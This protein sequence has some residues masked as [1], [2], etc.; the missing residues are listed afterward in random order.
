MRFL[1][2]EISWYGR[3]YF[4][5]WFVMIGRKLNELYDSVLDR[6]CQRLSSAL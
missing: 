3:D 4:P 2:M 6:V 1:Q 5:A